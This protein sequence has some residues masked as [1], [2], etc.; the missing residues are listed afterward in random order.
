MSYTLPYYPTPYLERCYSRAD[1]QVLQEGGGEGQREPVH[2][3]GD[4][5]EG[6]GGLGVIIYLTYPKP[7]LIKAILT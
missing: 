2:V 1:C 5:G 7:N 6:G 4:L 3:V